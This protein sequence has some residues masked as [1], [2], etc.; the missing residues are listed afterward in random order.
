M[1]IR[2]MKASRRRILVADSSKIGNVAR[3]KVGKLEDFD[4]LIYR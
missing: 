2:F 3:A 1:K 4:L